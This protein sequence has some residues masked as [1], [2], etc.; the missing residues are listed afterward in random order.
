MRGMIFARN[1]QRDSAPL[2][3][4]LEVTKTKLSKIV[5]VYI[6]QSVYIYTWTAVVWGLRKIY[7]K[8]GPTTVND[9]VGKCG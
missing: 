8:M 6:V 1:T 4:Q 5:S 9:V 3:W 7:M 2:N